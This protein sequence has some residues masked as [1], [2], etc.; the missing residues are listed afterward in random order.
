MEQDVLLL[1]R[2]PRESLPG[3]YTHAAA[4]VFTSWCENC[5]ITLLEAMGCGAAIACSNV[6]PM[7]EIC[8]DAARY[9][10]PWKVE[11]IRD[12]ILS[13]LDRP[14]LAAELRR[15]ALERSRAFQWR[16]T[17]ELTLEA[18]KTAAGVAPAPGGVLSR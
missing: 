3:L 10:D 17:A 1:G 4:F 7:P 5:P 8:G 15:R 18:F 6:P 11:E 12:G 9:F 16:K 13:V 2:V 14:D